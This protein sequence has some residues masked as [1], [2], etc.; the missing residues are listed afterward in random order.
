MKLE[1]IRGEFITRS[2]RNDLVKALYGVT[3]IDNG[4]NFFI[5]AGQRFLDLK[6]SNPESINRYIADISSG[7]YKLL[8]TDCRAIGEVWIAN[9]DGRVQLTKKSLNW[10]RTEYGE[11]YS[12][13]DTG[14]PLYYAPMVYR[15]SP[16][17]A[18]LTS[19]DFT[20]KYDYGGISFSKIGYKGVI[21]VPPADGTYT[22]NVFGLFFSGTL[23]DSI[24]AV[25]DMTFSGQ[26]S[27]AETFLLDTTTFTFVTA[28]AATDAEIKI[29]T[30]T[31]ASI[32]AAA[33]VINN[34]MTT[35]VAG[36]GSD[37][38]TARLRITAVD[39]GVD[40]NSIV[41]T[42]DLSNV[43][44]NGSGVLGGTTPGVDK[45]ENSYWSDVYPEVLIYSALWAIESFYRNRE[46]M[47]DWE[48]AIRVYLDGIDM[49]IV[50]QEIV[51]IDQMIG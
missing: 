23:V 9:T 42:E 47:R 44:I 31:D 37:S 46:G 30:D 6:Q 14:E 2:G 39:G 45:L 28:S 7:T 50:E 27:N 49:D 3:N 24:K 36:N 4:A 17:Q 18:L 12:S 35:I 33:I 38:F 16:S 25:G 40:G 5:N 34:K 1:D 20:G 19:S 10:I 32:T 43:T 51:G 15:L 41:F 13:L 48:S 29:G 11:D 8:F 26:P 22:V 21:I